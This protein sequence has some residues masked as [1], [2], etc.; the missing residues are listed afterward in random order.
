MV[1][2]FNYNR[3]FASFWLCEQELV[4]ALVSNWKPCSLVLYITE[5]IQNS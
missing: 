1:L 4:A 2:P 5:E 3:S